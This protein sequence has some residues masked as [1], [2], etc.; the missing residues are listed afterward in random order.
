[1]P[2]SIRITSD[3]D[4]AKITTALTG[5]NYDLYDGRVTVASDDFGPTVRALNAMGITTHCDQEIIDYDA[6]AVGEISME[7]FQAL[8]ASP[9]QTVVQKQVAVRSYKFLE[10]DEPV[11]IIAFSQVFYKHKTSGKMY[12]R[13][14]KEAV[15]EF[16]QDPDK[17]VI[18]DEL[19]MESGWQPIENTLLKDDK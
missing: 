12:I 18:A 5:I 9:S 8:S 7:F 6:E 10:D 4:E 16:L 13:D 1:M 15:F 3:V 19:D 2:A 11:F 17:C 14:S